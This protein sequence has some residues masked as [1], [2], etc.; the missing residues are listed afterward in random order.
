MCDRTFKDAAGYSFINGEKT[1]AIDVRKRLSANLIKTVEASQETVSQSRNQFSADMDI[2][3]TF[4]SSEM[5]NQMVNELQGNIITAMCL[6]LILVVATLG[7][8]SGLLVGF[9][10]PFCLLGALIIV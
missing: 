7:I 1:I 10:I 4:D 2:G 9:G 3:Y 6:V 8:K 5:T